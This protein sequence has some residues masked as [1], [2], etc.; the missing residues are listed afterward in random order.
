MNSIAYSYQIRH[1][2]PE[3]MIIN[4]SDAIKDDNGDWLKERAFFYIIFNGAFVVTTLK[5]KNRPKQE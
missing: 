2:E 1:V 5:F 3:D 4:A